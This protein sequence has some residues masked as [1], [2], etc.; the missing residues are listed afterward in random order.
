MNQKPS[1][2]DGF[3]RAVKR[4]RYLSRDRNQSASEQVIADQQAS[5]NQEDSQK[6]IGKDEHH[7]HAHRKPEYRVCNYPLH[8]LISF[9]ADSPAVTGKKHPFPD[10]SMQKRADNFLFIRPFIIFLCRL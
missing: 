7:K 4:L 5:C 9:R 10:Y 3:L 2:S 8:L 6:F 1:V